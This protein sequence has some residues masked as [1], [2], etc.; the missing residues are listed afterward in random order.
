MLTYQWLN[1]S[2]QRFYKIDVTKDGT[3]VVFNYHWGSCITNRGGKKSILLYSQE[4]AQK[5]IE[6]LIK[7]RKNRGYD[8]ITP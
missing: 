5:T 3:N 1:K 2:K 4:E 8:L 7:R 6:K